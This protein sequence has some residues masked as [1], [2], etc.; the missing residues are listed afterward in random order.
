MVI[1]VIVGLGNPE[2]ERE[3]TRHNAGFDVMRT[4]C[5]RGSFVFMPELQAEVAIIETP[6]GK[7]ALACPTTGMNSSGEAAKALLAHFGLSSNDLLMVYDDVSLPMGKLRFQ[8]HGGAGGHHGIESTIEQLGSREFERLKVGVGPDPG[9]AERYIFVLKQMEGEELDFFRE[10]LT[11][12]AESV[13]DWVRDGTNAVMCK[14][15]GRD[16]RKK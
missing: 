4:M 2:P 9:G 13:L 3:R 7:V 11:T 16:L 15:N 14:Y 6:A 5:E 12:C 10:V 8:H 1:K